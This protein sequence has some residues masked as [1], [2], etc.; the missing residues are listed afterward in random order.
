M[1]INISTFK[2][3]ITRMELINSY[4][5]RGEK[6]PEE[7]TKTFVLFPLSDNPYLDIK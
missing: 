3:Q 5:Q 6:I 4:I 7:L 1:K 2:A